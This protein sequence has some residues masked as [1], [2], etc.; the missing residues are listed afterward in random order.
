MVRSKTEEGI[1]TLDTFDHVGKWTLHAQF[2][3]GRDI[4]EGV[5]D[6]NG[7]ALAFAWKSFCTA[8]SKEDLQ[9]LLKGEFGFGE[10]AGREK[11]KG[12]LRRFL[13]V[14]SDQHQHS[15]N[16]RWR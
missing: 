10:E 3:V 5:A 11:F 9:T 4:P 6:D 15:S 1:R 14:A 8:L 16:R 2:E 13:G 7:E 12:E